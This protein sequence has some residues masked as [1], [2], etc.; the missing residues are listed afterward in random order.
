[1]RLRRKILSAIAVGFAVA[2]VAA[3]AGCDRRLYY[4]AFSPDDLYTPIVLIPYDVSTK[5]YSYTGTFVNKY[6]GLHGIGFIVP[7]PPPLGEGYVIDFALDVT[8]TDGKQ[9][10]LSRRA[11]NPILPFWGGGSGRSGVAVLDY[12]VPGDLP[13][14]M[15]LTITVEVVQSDPRFLELY[16]SPQLFVQKF[17]DE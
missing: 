10:L 6:P 13:E 9:L 8:V 1:M 14:D 17:S 15:V 12:H 11:N 2:Y 5:G 3:S 16:G 4:L 7:K